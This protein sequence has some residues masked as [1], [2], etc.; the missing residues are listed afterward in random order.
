[1]P[2]RQMNSY[3][4]IVDAG[5]LWKLWLLIAGLTAVGTLLS[6]LT[7][8]DSPSEHTASVFALGC[9]LVA[10]PLAVAF[11]YRRISAKTRSRSI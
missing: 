6:L 7:F 3:A 10:M 2:R 8:I 11:R 4:H 9:G 5:A 1:M